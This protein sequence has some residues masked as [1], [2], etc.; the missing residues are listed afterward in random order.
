MDMPLF[1]T[2]KFFNKSNNTFIGLN[3]N[4]ILDKISNSN[5]LNNLNNFNN[6]IKLFN[7]PKININ[8]NNPD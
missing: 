8:I 4:S 2:N 1:D 5:N 6:G 7:Q 3:N